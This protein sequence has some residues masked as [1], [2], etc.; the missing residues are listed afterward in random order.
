[1][2]KGDSDRAYKA[3]DMIIIGLQANVNKVENKSAILM[4][5]K[6]EC[7]NER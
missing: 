2:T 1:L 5:I 4:S 3:I 6:G 7:P